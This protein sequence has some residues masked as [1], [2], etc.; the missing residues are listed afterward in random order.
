MLLLSRLPA[1]A[2]A[3]E[4]SGL[5][6][7]GNGSSSASSAADDRPCQGWRA[8]W[9]GG[10]EVAQWGIRVSRHATSDHYVSRLL[11]VLGDLAAASSPSG[12]A[13]L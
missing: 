8:G 10:G 9:M 4:A 13:G 1:V 12:T 2:G 7:S 3:A 5:A 6:D 11:G